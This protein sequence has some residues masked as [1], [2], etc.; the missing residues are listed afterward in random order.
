MV[1]NKQT[2]LRVYAIIAAAIMVVFGA[3]T[4][5]PLGFSDWMLHVIPVALCIFQSRPEASYVVGTACTGTLI[6]GY[7]LSPEGA[8]DV[9]SA[10]NRMFGVVV[11]FGVAHLVGRVV[12]D[13]LHSRQA[14]WLQR[15]KIEVGKSMSG[16][17]DVHTLGHNLLQE[18]A[19]YVGAQVGKLYRL[20][21]DRLLLLAAYAY[22]R[23]IDAEPPLGVG[24]GL[25]G[26][27]A[28]EGRPMLVSDIPPGYLEINS[29]LG[30]TSPQHILISPITADNR[31]CGIIELGFCGTRQSFADQLELL[32]QIAEPAGIALRSAQDR[33]HLNELLEETQRQSEALQSQHEELRVT[34]EELE[35]Q[36]RVLRESQARL[37]NQQV[38]LEANN[39]QLEEQSQTLEHQKAELLRSKLHLEKNAE[40]LARANQYKSEFLANMSHELRTPLNSSLILSQILAENKTN[41]LTE[42]QVRY[43]K[44]IQSSNKALL[45]LINDILDLSKIEAGHMNVEPEQVSLASILDALRQLFEPLAREKNLAFTVEA[46]PGAPP[47]LTTDNGRLQQIMKNLISNALKFTQ[48]GEVAV[49]AFPAGAGRIAFAVRDT[50]IGIPEHQQDFVFEA[51]RQADGTTSRTYGGTGLG[52]SISRE[53]AHL[54]GGEIRLQSSPGQGSVFTLE[55]PVE[56]RRLPP[57]HERE[58]PADSSPSPPSPPRAPAPRPAPRQAPRRVT[59]DV[60][61]TEDAPA[62]VEDDRRHRQYERLIL[63]IED[64][65]RFAAVL[66]DLAHERKFDCLHATTAAEA[67]RLAREYRPHGILLD[68]GL[69]DQSGLSVLE[70]LKR[71]SSTRHIP[72]HV[73]SS[74]DQVQAAYELGAIGYAVKPVARDELFAAIGRLEDKLQ[75]RV[76]RLLI[77]EDNQAQRESLE[78]MLKADD[79]EITMAGTVAEALTHISQTTFDCV[80]M[81]LMLPDASG[82]D[83]LEKMA[84][85]G[86]YAFPP[87]I[88]YTGRNLSRDEEQRLRRYSQSIII[89]SAKSPARLLDEVTLFLHRVES[90][91]PPA[92]QQL[93]LQAKQRDTA[94]ENRKILL[95]EDD[96]RNI[97]ALTSVFEPLGAEVE[98]ARNGKEA[99][100]KLDGGKAARDF[101]LVLMDLMMPEMDGLTAT[102]EIRK[103]P[104][105]ARLPIIA[106]TAKA[107]ADDRKSCLEAGAND[108]IA[109]PIDIDKLVSLTRIWMPK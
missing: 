81:D 80:V 106:L 4:V 98:I 100:A 56:L 13:N 19:T 30:H 22:D 103:R 21:G 107:M 68:I 46:D 31:V 26:E 34:N 67:V 44:T 23:P 55:I 102:R 1:L 41:T 82:Y 92:Q 58:Q 6:A 50:G 14:L 52:L 63:L 83:L 17:Q 15:G 33:A 9:P 104:E 73:V 37:E 20:D 72:I 71:D 84:D 12:R 27:A 99:L 18:L 93:L 45:A 108:Y 43:A 36:S 38:E 32:A 90:A 95:V 87:V 75:N 11:I 97:F 85:G 77:V 69:P 61:E 76:R 105:L 10:L 49:H 25:A 29:S 5:T 101:D 2:D 78:A 57:R 51:F 3:D 47:M 65:Q 54:L 60:Q 74:S 88:V 64:D 70:T 24:Q 16:D 8:A 59:G 86:K 109:K 40:E 35:E 7:F 53:L 66:R 39:A 42:E 96:V 79:I 91:L 62:A 89:K 94:F 48:R 28:R